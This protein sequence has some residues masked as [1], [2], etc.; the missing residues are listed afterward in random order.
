MR[1]KVKRLEGK[2]TELVKLTKNSER[3]AA[4]KLP[5]NWHMPL[6]ITG[7]I[8][9]QRTKLKESQA[10]LR[11]L[12]LHVSQ[13]QHLI[14]HG[15]EDEMGSNVDDNEEDS[16]I[17]SVGNLSLGEDSGEESSLGLINAVV[18]FLLDFSKSCQKRL[19][20]C[21]STRRMSESCEKAAVRVYKKGDH[22]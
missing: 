1:D 11:K 20:T 19:C 15:S 4:G 12:E 9:K 14:D 21:T 10:E 5:A 7:D 16:D 22:V 18:L 3:L 6:R 2:I 17:L 8:G 13:I